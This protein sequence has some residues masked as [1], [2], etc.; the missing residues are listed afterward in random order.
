MNDQDEMFE[1]ATELPAAFGC[2]AHM[3]KQLPSGF[4][5]TEPGEKSKS[6]VEVEQ[7]KPSMDFGSF[8]VVR[9]AIPGMSMLSFRRKQE[10]LECGSLVPGRI[11]VAEIR[12]KDVGGE[13]LVNRFTVKSY[14]PGMEARVLYAGD[15][16]VSMSKTEKMVY[17]M[18]KTDIKETQRRHITRKRKRRDSKEVK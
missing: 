3:P 7:R 2:P 11:I 12:K 14:E 13:K 6:E 4:D 5:G 18:V 8:R 17:K 1:R 15:S 9:F 16:W 10:K